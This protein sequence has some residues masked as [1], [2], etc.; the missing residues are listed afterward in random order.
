[1]FHHKYSCFCFDSF[2]PEVDPVLQHLISQIL[3]SLNKECYFIVQEMKDLKE[4]V[5]KSYIDQLNKSHHLLEVKQKELLEVN[6]I[7]AEQKHAMED[8][9]ERLSASIQ[10]CSEANEIMNR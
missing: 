9:N 7:S 5:T 1:M 3:P 2:S 6:R 8:L 10:S 4:S